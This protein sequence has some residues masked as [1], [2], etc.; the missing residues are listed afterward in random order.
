MLAGQTLDGILNNMKIVDIASEIYQDIGS[1]SG[2]SIPVIASWLRNNIGQLNNALNT[3]YYVNDDLEV[4]YLNCDD[5][6]IEIGQE[7][8]AIFKKI[9]TIH[10]YDIEIR[11]NIISYTNAPVIEVTS[12]GNSVRRVSVSE[13]GKNLYSFRKNEGDELQNMINQYKIR[14]SKPRQVAGDDTVAASQ[15]DSTIYTRL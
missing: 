4:V 15:T 1:P 10:Y 13:L 8:V 5:E 3:E 6:E 14:A 11:K 9:Y 12:D 7:E 2:L